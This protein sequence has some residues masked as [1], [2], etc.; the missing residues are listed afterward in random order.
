[1]DVVH[2]AWSAGMLL[3]IGAAVLDRLHTWLAA[4]WDLSRRSRMTL[5]AALLV[6]PMLAASAQL[7]GWRALPYVTPDAAP[8]APQLQ[9]LVRLDTLPVVD[10]LWLSPAVRDEL[11]RL[12][13]ELHRG[14]APGEPI[15]VYPAAPLIYLLAERPNPTRYDHLYPGTV[16][17]AELVRLVA[18]LE[19]THLPTVV[20]SE[21]SLLDPPQRHTP[22][23]HAPP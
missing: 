16:P 21:Y 22:P 13:D 1:M 6:V 15:F 10:N 4:R 2:L 14:T 11:S 18:T 8:G 20:P 23:F 12:V 5:A 3:V 17:P 7:V 19:Q 9:S